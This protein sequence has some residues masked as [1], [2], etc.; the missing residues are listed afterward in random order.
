[1]SYAL[2]I[3]LG[4]TYTSAAVAT[5]GRV[6]VVQLGMRSSAV[7][8]VVFLTEAGELLTGDSANRRAVTAPERV[9]REFKRRVGDTAPLLLGGTPMAPQALMGTMLR[10]VADQVTTERGEPPAHVA[11][12]HPA[13]WGPYKLDLLHQ[14]VRLAD[15]RTATTITEPEAA[16][17]Y[18]AST[19]RLSPGDIVAVYDLG[20]GTFDAAV[21]QAQESGF[22]ILG[23]PE[24][25]EHLG[26]ID[27]DEAVFGF[28]A[29]SLDGALEELDLDDPLVTSAAARLRRDCVDAKEALSSDPEVVVPVMLP[30]VQT[31]VRITRDELEAMVRPSLVATIGA[32]ERALRS[33]DVTPD[34]LAAVLLVGGASRM[35]LVAELVGEALGRPVAVDA[36]PKHAVSLGTALAAEAAHLG[37]QGLRQPTAEIIAPVTSPPLSPVE[38]VTPSQPP[39]SEGRR[40][41]AAPIPTPP[42]G[43]DTVPAA[44]PAPPPTPGRDTAPVGGPTPPPAPG[45][46]NLPAGA[47]AAASERDTVAA[48]GPPPSVA[49]AVGD[50]PDG[51]GNKRRLLY[52]GLPLV[53]LVI[54]AV[55]LLALRGGGDDRA[56]EA[57]EP[58]ASPT[59]EP[60]GAPTAE[61]T[62]GDGTEP[63]SAPETAAT[64]DATE[65]NGTSGSSEAD[66]TTVPASGPSAEIAGL[67]T[68]RR[69]PVGQFPDGIAV[70]GAGRLWVASTF[71][72]QVTRIDPT[73]GEGQVV[74][75]PG[76]SA[77]LGV[78]ASEDGVFVTFHTAGLM[79]R[80]NPDTLEHSPLEVSAQPAAQGWGAGSLWV[81]GESGTVDRID[82]G[83]FERTATVAVVS[84]KGVAFD[85]QSVWVT[86]ANSGNVT[87]IDPA[88]NE[89][90]G[91][92]FV[93]TS[94]D[95]LAS[96]G[97]ALW[98]ANRGEGTLARFDLATEQVTDRIDVGTGP[99]AVMIDGDRVWVVDVEEGTLVLVDRVSGTVVNSIPV[100]ARPLGLVPIGDR[101]WVTL[102]GD[103]AVVEVVVA[104]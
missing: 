99:A 51:S 58:T 44:P 54:A 10:W 35:P 40:T 57:G 98:I 33:A 3:D 65:P 81:V 74:D 82:P 13:N 93:G 80:V 41:I 95:G 20:G 96:D 102:T 63:T 77:P 78:A 47:P 18:Y 50:K 97:E 67:T 91:S 8:T 61:P 34:D 45:D 85:G 14:A 83:A 103:N 69:I 38:P 23:T 28:V 11:V 22:E 66:A 17:R 6:E 16:A 71:A 5:D 32:L 1:M 24:G 90:V 26:G 25:I 12:S 92:Y 9:A 70:D 46:H 27:V 88:T 36:H 73:T 7:P 101:V 37:S 72:D 89:V 19:R 21:V 4:T 76:G 49:A 79:A 39:A 56:E 55:V 52:I 62:A 100:G 75:F 84:P 68:G 43:R 15:L 60:T 59:A 2:G 48:G 30:G 104:S 29:R 31:E 87:K 94:P 53:A 86:E 64:S 42:P